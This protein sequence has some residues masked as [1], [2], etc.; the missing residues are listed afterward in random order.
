VVVEA[1]D[2]AL[3]LLGVSL[4]EL[5]AA[6]RGAF[7]AQP[8]SE[9]EQAALRREWEHAGAPDLG[10]ESTILR[11]DGSEQRVRYLVSREAD[12][13]LIIV[14]VP[15]DGATDQRPTVYALGD[16]ITSWR[17]AERQ[18]ETVAP[19]SS[20]WRAVKAEIMSLRDAYHRSY[21]ARA[22]V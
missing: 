9:G 6:P 7:S 5:R 22:A 15:I 16:V 17:A 1:N 21:R 10:G 4:A 20:E 13:H 14:L 19:N 3:E 8:Q 2:A 11:A 18:L 12:G